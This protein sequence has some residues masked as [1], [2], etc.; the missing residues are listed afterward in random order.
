[1]NAID[2]QLRE[3]AR[4][5][6]RAKRIALYADWLAHDCDGLAFNLSYPPGDAPADATAV[7]ADAR[8]RVALALAFIDQAIAADKQAHQEQER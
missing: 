1:M 8:E 4:H 6:A 7:L 3:A 5:E 2:A